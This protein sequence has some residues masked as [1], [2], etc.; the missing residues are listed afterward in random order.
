MWK[1]IHCADIHLDS[2]LR[3]LDRYEGAPTAELR[4]STREALANLVELALAERVKFV[5]IAGDLYDG[6]WEDYGTGLSLNTQLARLGEEGIR[7]YLIRGN[8]DAES[9]ITH[10]LTLPENVVMLRTD[11]PETR[12]DDDL[13]VAVHGQG[14][15][16]RAVTAN[17][18]EHYP[19][20]RPHYFNLGLLHTCATGRD[21]HD[22][23]APCTIEQLRARD[24]DYWALGHIHK[25]ELLHNDPPILFPGNLQGRHARELGA[26]GCMLVTVESGRVANLEHRALDVVRW[27]VARVDAAG[28]DDLA[29]VLDRVRLRLAELDES[30]GGRTLAVRVEILGACRAHDEIAGAVDRVESE[31]RNVA[32]AVR[33][34]SVWVEKVKLRT[35]APRPIDDNDGP[36][37]EVLALL[38]ELRRDDDRLRALGV[39]ELTDLRKRLPRDLLTG[40][41][42]LDLESPALLRE[43]LDHVGPMLVGGL[44]GR[45]DLS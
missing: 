33:E 30:A 19:D 3:G 12:L 34:G 44:M 17:L 7:V 22:A 23:Y 32:R 29:D 28:A 5:A 20:R 15:A 10:R 4:R 41:E 18:A 36:I 14:F 24:Y 2:P 42:P 21:G 26:K 27:E 40:A 8:H 13:G 31:V 43:L 38:E 6:D 45:E 25:R 1:F 39:A 11:E 9:Q 35:R 16:T 37:G